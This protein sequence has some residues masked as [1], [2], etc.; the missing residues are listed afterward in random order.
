M[1][2][3]A[4]VF[5]FLGTVLAAI[6]VVVVARRLRTLNL[7]RLLAIGAILVVVG[8]GVYVLRGS[9]VTNYLGF[10]GVTEP[11]KSTAGHVETGE[12]RT[13]LLWMGWQMWKDHPVLGLGHRPVEHGLPAVSRRTQATVP[14]PAGRGLPVEA[15]PV[16][17][18]ELLAR[19]R[20]DMGMP[21]FVLG[22]VDLPRGARARVQGRAREPV[23]P[24]LVATGF[25]LVAAGTWNAI[26]IVAGIP[27]DAVTWLGLGL[28]ATAIPLAATVPA[29]GPSMISGSL[30]DGS[31]ASPVDSG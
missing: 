9:D 27:L 16:G 26:G 7:A 10:L 4:S 6:A 2:I 20:S 13:L 17:R 24:R 21:G 30:S 22:V 12:Q 1:I 31:L 5:A 14:R 28:A 25:I 8:S 3:D 11:A 29:R 19:A 23:L 15:E 18:A